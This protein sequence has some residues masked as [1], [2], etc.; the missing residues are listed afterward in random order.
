[1]LAKQMG[2]AIYFVE[3]RYFGESLPFGNNTWDAANLFYLTAD[4]ALA[5][6][7]YFLTELKSTMPWDCPVFSFG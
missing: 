3:H 7:A 5:D 1:M 4:Q 6:Y 2:A